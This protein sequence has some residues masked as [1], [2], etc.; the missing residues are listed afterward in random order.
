MKR[1]L[2]K[3]KREKREGEEKIKIGPRQPRLGEFGIFRQFFS[4]ACLDME[5]PAVVK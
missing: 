5:V 2:P 4:L 1:Y 3:E